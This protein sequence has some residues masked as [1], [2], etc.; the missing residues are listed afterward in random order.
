VKLPKA[1]QP[2]TVLTLE[3]LAEWLQ[4]GR[5]SVMAMGFRYIE[6]P[7]KQDRRRYLMKHILEDLDR[8]VAQ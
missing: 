8:K 1:Y 3:Q 5:D 6:A 2:E 7:G 4:L